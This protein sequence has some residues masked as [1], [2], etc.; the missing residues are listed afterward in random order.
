MLS[1]EI[2]SRFGNKFPQAN[3]RFIN[4]P[5]SGVKLRQ[6]LGSVWTT[7]TIDL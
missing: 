7:A 5:N 2:C 4:R 3:Q 6:N 1:E